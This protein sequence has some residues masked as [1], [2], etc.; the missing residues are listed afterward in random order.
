[1]FDA[2]VILFLKK[3]LLL[4][5]DFVQM[6]SVFAM[7]KISMQLLLNFILK[8]TRKQYDFREQL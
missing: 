3:F 2:E 7:I 5:A 1:M 8:Y 6:L 4:D